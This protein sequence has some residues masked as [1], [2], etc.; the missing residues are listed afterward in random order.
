MR[1][2][3]IYLTFIFSSVF[4]FAQEYVQQT[5]TS[6]VAPAPQGTIVPM[7]GA[8]LAPAEQRDS[9]LIGDQLMYGVE[10][11]LVEEGTDF[12]F[13]EWEND[14]NGGVMAI[15]PWIVDTVKVTRRKGDMPDLL[16]IRAGIVLTSFDEGEFDLPQIIIQR[17]SLE[18]AV[19]TLIFE[20]VRMDVKT[21]PV[22]TATFVPHDIKGQIRYP[23]TVREVLPWIVGSKWAAMLIILAICLFIIFRK[24]ND[25]AAKPSEPAHI[26]ALRELDKYRGKAMWVPEKQ[27]AF[28]SGITDALREYM[29]RRYD[30]GAMEMTTSEIFDDMKK[31]DAPKELLHEMKELFERADFVK[32]AK[33][34][35]SDEDNAAALPVAVRFVTS[36]Y[37][38]DVENAPD[39]QNEKEEA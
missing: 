20:P 2:A 21:M 16:D 4:L 15:T 7:R 3:L 5:D 23:V 38:A 33:Y 27:K 26:V 11:R 34:I 35:A 10:L 13:P 28:Y 25:I 6:E 17:H 9:I 30:I 32:F 37:Q 24:K 1:K 31:T 29:S 19:D 22:D 12:A 18:G 36:T 14:P 39:E 8:F